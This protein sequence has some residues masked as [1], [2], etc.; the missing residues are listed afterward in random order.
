MNFIKKSKSSSLEFN[1]TG[2][3]KRFYRKLPKISYLTIKE[4]KLDYEV[5]DEI[6]DLPDEFL[7][8]NEDNFDP[9][10]CLE[11]IEKIPK[12]DWLISY[13]Q[14]YEYHAVLVTDFQ[15]WVNIYLNSREE[16]ESHWR[17]DFFLNGN[18]YPF[19]HGK[20]LIRYIESIH[21]MPKTPLE[22]I[23]V[24]DQIRATLFMEKCGLR[25]LLFV[26]TIHI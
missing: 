22:F 21:P 14:G 20:N 25:M 12:K 3:K 10:R 16:R 9:R 15:F 7:S 4:S 11:I 26:I 23:F 13:G 18:R 8:L 17:K 6:I 2:F 1:K 5:I 19:D 24:I